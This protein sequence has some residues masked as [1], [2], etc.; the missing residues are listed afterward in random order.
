DFWAPWCGPCRVLGPVLERVAQKQVGRWELVK[1][2]T[3]ENQEVSAEYGIRGIPA[4]KLFVDGAVVDEFT[5]ALPEPAF[6]QWLDKAIPSE[7][8]QKI[9]NAD[10]AIQTGDIQSAR[11]L[12]EEVLTDEPTNAEASGLLSRLVVWDEPARASELSKVA[13]TGSGELVRM[14][15][16]VAELASVLTPSTDTALPD[17]PGKEAFQRAIASIRS[18]DLSS[19]L[20]DLIHV[21]TIDRYYADD[22]ARKICI[23]L[24]DILGEEHAATREYRRRFDMSLY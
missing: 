4:V 19:A 18:G 8:K 23:A 20:E 11:A 2:N 12:L 15:S 21:I 10:E 14:A 6:K 5:G 16:S 13:N 7:N 1:I 24:F 22:R 9:R 17:G 3:D